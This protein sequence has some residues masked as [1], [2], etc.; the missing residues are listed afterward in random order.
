MN[1]SLKEA[2]VWVA[3]VENEVFKGK[4]TQETKLR[5]LEQALGIQ[6][7]L[8]DVSSEARKLEEYF[9]GFISLQL[10]TRKTSN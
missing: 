2:K 5:R 8:Q 7:G 3:K 10:V 6:K 9:L 1:N 4:T